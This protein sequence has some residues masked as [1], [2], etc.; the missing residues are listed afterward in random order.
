MW[1]HKKLN[2]HHL[3]TTNP[4]LHFKGRDY[5]AIFFSQG[6]Q[7]PGMYK[8]S[9][10]WQQWF[11]WYLTCL[12]LT[13]LVLTKLGGG[14]V[15]KCSGRLKKKKC[16]CVQQLTKEVKILY[17]PTIQ[18]SQF[19][20]KNK[21]GQ[22]SQCGKKKMLRWSTPKCIFS[23]CDLLQCSKCVYVDVWACVYL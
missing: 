5:C 22:W 21:L 1:Y 14:G 9:P 16:R 6:P 12:L 23:S 17:T 10:A 18:F 4:I 11:G 13:H 3:T 20:F 7:Q 19:L 2:G 8:R 15:N